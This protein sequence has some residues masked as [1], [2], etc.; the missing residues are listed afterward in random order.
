MVTLGREWARDLLTLP[1]VSQGRVILLRRDAAARALWDQIA[2]VTP[3]ARRA[4]D[5]ALDACGIADHR[6]AAVRRDFDRLLRVQEELHL[7]HEIGEIRETGFPRDL[8]QEIVAA[9]PLTRVE[10]VMRRV[11]DLLADTHPSGPLPRFCEAR[12]TAGLALYMANSDRAARALFPDLS[13][14]FDALLRDGEWGALEQAI[15]G[16]RESARTHATAII[17]AYAEGPARLEAVVEER[18]GA[19]LGRLPQEA[20]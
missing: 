6:P 15:A 18:F 12:N 13:Q 3:S 10:L 17:A 14:G 9:F 2:F 19:V 4:M 16:G 11:K 7:R 20:D 1:A 8:W 5:A